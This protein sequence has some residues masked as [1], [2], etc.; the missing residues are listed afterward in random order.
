VL[1][2]YFGGSGYGPGALTPGTDPVPRV[3]EDGWASN[4]VWANADNLASSGSEPRSV[5]L[6]ASRYTDYAITAIL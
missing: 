4:P 2:E 1:E 5:Q 3:Q 6:V